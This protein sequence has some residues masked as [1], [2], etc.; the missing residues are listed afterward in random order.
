MVGKTLTL[1]DV[2]NEDQLACR[3]SEHWLDWNLR[4]KKK[5]ADWN[6]VRSYIYA[7]DTTQTSNAQLPW[8]NKTTLPK[9]TQ[10]RD[11]LFANYMATMFP[12]RRWLKWEG[13]TEGDENKREAILDYMFWTISQ[14]EFK[15]T[16]KKLVLDYIDFGNCIATVEWCDETTVDSDGRTRI[17]YTGPRAVRI[18]PLDIVFNPIAPH[19][20]SSP[21][22]VRALMSM[23][24]AKKLLEQYTVEEHQV[25]LANE[26]FD[27]CKEL[28]D[29]T[30]S[31]SITDFA[32]HNE[33]YTID[34]FDSYVSYLGSNYV[35]LLF[36]Y[37]DLYD[38]DKDKFYQNHMF[39]VIDRHKLVYSGKHPYTMAEIPMYHT[40]WRPRQDNLWAMGPLDNLV[41][42]QYRLDHVEN[43]KADMLD[44]TAFPPVKI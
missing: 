10:V 6:E 4:R 29:R 38:K 44:L 17:G 20:S 34:G 25:T 1:E 37:G 26:V 5:V 21:K 42:L 9:L 2:L 31:E 24:E 41:G 43:M 16:I 13:W 15:D 33:Y 22:I 8:S 7:T 30:S 3:I 11:N 18:N 14:R 36:F 40:G 28:R 27:Y 19:F 23:G 32:S 35:E 12:K 39:V